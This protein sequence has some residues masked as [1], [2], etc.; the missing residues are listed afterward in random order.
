MNLKKKIFLKV[1]AFI[2][3]YIPNIAAVL[4]LDLSINILNPVIATGEFPT[5]LCAVKILTDLASK[6]SENFTEHHLDVI[7][8]NIALVSFLEY[9]P[10]IPVDF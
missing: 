6:Q 2:E 5:N 8:P 7:M 9:F 10:L 4:P 1:A 3:V